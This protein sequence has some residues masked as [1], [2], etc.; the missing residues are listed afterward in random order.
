M[1]SRIATPK[2]YKKKY[3]NRSCCHNFQKMKNHNNILQQKSRY[4]IRKIYLTLKK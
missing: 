2:F 3:K 1:K 4:K